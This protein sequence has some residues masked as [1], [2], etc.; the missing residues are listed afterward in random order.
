MVTN[1]D[2][3]GLRL[4]QADP[5]SGDLAPDAAVAIVRKELKRDPSTPFYV[6]VFCIDKKTHGCVSWSGFMG[7]PN[8]TEG[9]WVL[10][11]PGVSGDF[12][13]AW[14]GVDATTGEVVLGDWGTG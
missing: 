3:Q 9:I 7:E 14:V 6:E 13:P 12:G 2:G 8:E 10:T 4:R 11:F 1:L 5:R